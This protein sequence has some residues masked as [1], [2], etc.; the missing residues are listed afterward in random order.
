MKDGGKQ[1]NVSMKKGVGGDETGSEKTTAPASSAGGPL[2]PLQFLRQNPS[3]L[4]QQS[5]PPSLFIL[6]LSFLF[7]Y[8]QTWL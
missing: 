4:I 1:V 6:F 2:A 3:S 5:L 8:W 7:Y